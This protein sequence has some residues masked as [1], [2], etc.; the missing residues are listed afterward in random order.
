M[1]QKSKGDITDILFP[2]GLRSS[3]KDDMVD[4]YIFLL[5]NFNLKK[6]SCISIKE[7]SGVAALIPHQT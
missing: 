7:P 3:V 6:A 5:L 2:I 4:V 1:R